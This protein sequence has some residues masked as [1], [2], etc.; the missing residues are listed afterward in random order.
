VARPL[1]ASSRAGATAFRPATPDAL[2]V[3]DAGDTGLSR[4]GPPPRG[5]RRVA[6]SASADGRPDSALGDVQPDAWC[7]LD[8]LARIRKPMPNPSN[9]IRLRPVNEVCLR[10]APDPIVVSVEAVRVA[11][12]DREVISRHVGAIQVWRRGRNAE[13]RIG[14][15][16]RRRRR[17]RRRRSGIAVRQERALDNSSDV[18]AAVDACS[19]N[20]KSSGD[21][22]SA[23]ITSEKSVGAR[24]AE[25]FVD[26]TPAN[27]PVASW[28]SE[29][30][31][32]AK[33]AKETIGSP[34]AEQHIRPT[35]TAENVIAAETAD[36]V[37]NPGADQGVASCRPAQRACET[38]D[39]EAA[40]VPTGITR[41]RVLRFVPVSVVVLVSLDVGIQEQFNVEDHLIG[42]PVFS[43]Q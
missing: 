2:L 27:K 26:H 9:Q 17:G 20:S 40:T 11:A 24:A 35:A 36:H 3:G 32:A 22:F 42:G 10:L 1:G 31:S 15:T 6:D 30:A 34:A 13:V 43:H 41:T 12:D 23:P 18:E 38:R 19:V 25:E 28:P 37:A 4:H 39:D 7:H 29:K 33:S 8:R 16:A 14:R 21:A 5:V